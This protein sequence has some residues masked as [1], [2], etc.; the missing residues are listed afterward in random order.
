MGMGWN[1]TDEASG[2]G[3]SFGIGRR[4]AIGALLAVL[5]V[6]GAGGWAATARLSGAVI[7]Q[8]SVVVDEELKAIQHRDGG[9]VREI[10]VREG[11]EVEEGQILIRL[12][13]AQTRAELSIIRS[14]LVENRI[15]RARLLAE[16][17]S[18]KM[19]EFP[20]DLDRS[21]AEIAALVLGETRLFD[22][23]RTSR[24]SQKQQLELSIR[25]IGDEIRGLT[26]QRVS[27]E[28]EIALVSD[29]HGKMT[30]LY[31]K[32]L[33]QASQISG[34]DRELARLDGEVGEIDAELAR[35]DA[36]ISEI[37]LKIL[38]TDEE[39]RTEA[40]RELSLVATRLSELTDREMAVEDRLSRTDI[41][42][43][44]AGVV[45]ELT[46]FTIGGIVTPAEVLATLVPREARLRVEIQLA[47]VSIDQ[48]A[49][50][51]PARLRFTSFNQRTT[52]ELVGQVLHVS[53]ATTLDPATGQHFFI[54]QIDVAQT[55]LEKLPSQRLLP[56]MTVEVYV[57]TEERTAF[58]YFAKPISDQFN[59]AFRER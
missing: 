12:E 27:K 10:A 9:I 43:P 50:G 41:R 29:E 18:L 57:Q 48:V 7:A 44:I 53:P 51:H 40:Q 2:K 39:A 20:Q 22:G 34:L 49:E 14:Q 37:R 13:D 17:D 11:D 42:A 25:Q 6:G 30:A 35:A 38:A 16:R 3:I 47:P 36:R 32:G 56:G 15:K 45:N 1:E 8:G 5:L 26:A 54:A 31:E 55:E 46:V 23:N 21:D 59:R 28:K 19:I 24:E 4:I 58:S 33:V 52:P